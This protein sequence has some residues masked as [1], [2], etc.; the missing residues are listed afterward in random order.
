MSHD[1]VAIVI[2]LRASRPYRLTRHMGRA[3]QQIFLRHIIEPIDPD[4]SQTLHDSDQQNPYTVTGLMQP[5]YHASLYGD[6]NEGDISWIRCVALNRDVAAVLYEWTLSP[7]GVL[8]V[9][10]MPWY[11]ENIYHG[12]VAH[13]AADSTNYRT[14][15][16][17]AHKKPPPRKINLAF[18]VPTAFH[19]NGM[20]MPFA[21]PNLVYGSLHRQW[22]LF[23]G[24]DLP[25]ELPAFIEHFLMLSR[26]DLETKMLT[27]KNGGKQV[28]FIGTATYEIAKRNQRLERVDAELNALLLDNHYMLGQIINLLTDFAYYSG[29]GI[30]TSTGM[31]M[32]RR[33]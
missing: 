20:N 18:S 19:S 26:Y 25:E 29:V 11:V 13:D 28:G 14:L 1:L 27:F 31:G 6:V 23:C 16:E 30:K 32:V 2:E 24:I 10:N 3:V 21:L 33:T 5:E 15:I 9:D 12:R 22:E 17:N 8:E 4:L 7:P